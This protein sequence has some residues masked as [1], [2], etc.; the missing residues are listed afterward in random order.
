MY[1]HVCIYMYVYTYI[2]ISICM[3]CIYMHI[4]ASA[5]ASGYVQLCSL[6]RCAPER[7]AAS[8]NAP[9]ARLLTC[10]SFTVL[11]TTYK[12]LW[13]FAQHITSCCL[14]VMLSWSHVVFSVLK[15]CCH[16]GGGPWIFSRV[17]WS[18]R[19]CMWTQKRFFSGFR[20]PLWGTRNTIS[21]C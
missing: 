2:Y 21:F 3:M 4:C 9:L 13:F 8:A 16:Y 1:I 6:A 19:K 14:D 10:V 12:I 20:I 5:Q 7:G 17:N 11:C 15:S 18:A